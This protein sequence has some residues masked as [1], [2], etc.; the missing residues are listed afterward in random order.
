MYNVSVCLS[1][2][3][4]EKITLA[5]NGKYYANLVVGDK[6]EKDQYGYDAYVAVSQTKEEREAGTPKTYCGRGNKVEFQ[7]RTAETH[8]FAPQP[9]SFAEE[10]PGDSGSR[11]S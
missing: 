8:P 2:I 1:D 11:V 7:Q 9:P 3:P 6:K 10:K 4:Q 5:S